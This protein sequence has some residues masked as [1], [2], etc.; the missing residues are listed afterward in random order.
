MRF[1]VTGCTGFIGIHLCRELI[2]RG[3]QVVGLVRNT[4]KLPP[5]FQDKL[6]VVEGDLSVFQDRSFRIPEVDVVIHLAAVTTA[7]NLKQ[8]AEVNYNAVEDMLLFLQQQEWQ[9]KRFLFVSSLAAAGP[10]PVD[11]ALSEDDPT[12]PIDAYGEAKSRAEGLMSKQPFPTTSI[13]PP[14]VLGPGDPSSLTLFKIAKFGVAMIPSG[15]SQLL[16]FI[17]VHD[18]VKAIFATAEDRS[19]EHKVYFAT[20]EEVITNEQLIRE[21]ARTLDKKIRVVRLPHWVFWSA[22]KW[23]TLLAKVFSFRNQLDKKQYIQM[24]TPAFVCTSQ[25]LTNELGWKAETGLAE[26][27]EKSLE[28]YRELGWL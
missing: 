17:F 12:K 21:V 25:K 19:N 20:H 16:S 7:K 8:Y 14:I 4:S 9:P 13:R 11:R 15:P 26:I 3:H 28:G 18:L 10:S 6:E 27:L 2:Q 5:D 23:M 22:M 1:F 24:V